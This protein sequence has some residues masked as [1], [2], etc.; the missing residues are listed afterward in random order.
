MNAGAHDE[1]AALFS[2]P[3]VLAID[4][5]VRGIAWDG[6]GEDDI[7]EIA[8]DR[9]TATARLRCMLHTETAIGPSCPLVDMAR[10]QGGGVVTRAEPGVFEG[11]YVKREGI[12]KILRLPAWRRRPAEP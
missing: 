11:V 7:V 4:P 6:F 5:D 3:S 8:E 9:Q 2:D 1:L 12:W 10:Q